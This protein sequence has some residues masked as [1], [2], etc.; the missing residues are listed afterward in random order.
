MSKSRS[1]VFSRLPPKGPGRYK[2]GR[3]KK[4]QNAPERGKKGRTQSSKDA[5]VVWGH[6]RV[7]GGK[8]D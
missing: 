7:K 8:T 4:K 3:R 5:S 2:K 6:D 1:C